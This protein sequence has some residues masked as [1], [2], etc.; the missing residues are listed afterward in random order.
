MA[1]KKGQGGRPKGVKNKKTLDK[2][3]VAA[4][5][6]AGA[7]VQL[8]AAANSPAAKVKALPRP[9]VKGVEVA[10]EGISAKDL[11]LAA[12]REAWDRHKA[13]S[14]RA[15]EIEETALGMLRDAAELPIKDN[16]QPAAHRL[17][18]AE[19]VEAANKVR[20][21]AA[22]IRIDSGAALA[23]ALDTAHKVAPF[24]HAKLQTQT[25]Q[26]DLQLHVTIAKF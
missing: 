1:F 5:V 20:E 11:M 22:G 14:L 21:Q 13:A 16:E 26:G 18:I 4:N 7:A 3:Q 2:E 6:M 17:R 8:A 25:V 12:M 24:D 23:L 19:A 15:S 9:K 10:P